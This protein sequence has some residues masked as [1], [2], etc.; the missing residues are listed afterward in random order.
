LT[1]EGY[2]LPDLVRLL[3]ALAREPW[4]VL[5][6]SFHSPSA[7]PGHTPYVR[8]EAEL[9]GFLSVLGGALEFAVER[10]GARCLTLSEFHAEFPAS[11]P[12]RRVYG[13][14]GPAD[15]APASRQPSLA[16]RV[17]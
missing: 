6:L 5:N 12:S 15:T 14:Q 7:E 13:G 4:P 1:P 11:G 9:E 3:R 17:P 8:S 2:G 16:A 10:L